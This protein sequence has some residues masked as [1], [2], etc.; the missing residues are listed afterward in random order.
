[1]NIKENAFKILNGMSIGIVCALVPGAIFGALAGAL[2]FGDIVFGLNICTSLMGLL[3]GLCIGLQFKLDPISSCSLAVATMIGGGAFKGVSEEGMILLKGTGD[4]INA[5]IGATLAIIIILYLKDRL[6]AYKLLL[7]PSITIISVTLVC[8]L[9]A[10]PVGQVSVAIG[11]MIETFTNLQPLLMSILIGMSFALI[12]ISPISTVAIAVLINLSGNGS[13]AANIG[14][15]GMSVTIAILA[16]KSNGFGTA[17]AHFLG[18]PKIQMANFFKNPTMMVPSMV[19]AAICAIS[20]PFL[21]LVGTPMSA[22]FG[23]S[24][25]I[26]PLGHLSETSFDTNNIIIVAI[27][28]FIIPT[29]VSFIVAYI[30]RNKLKLVTDDMYKLDV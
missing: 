8:G 17:I 10:G 19:S 29:I 4:V 1:M 22:G 24:G 15:I 18:S 7:L 2:G 5:A 20:V 12:I 25:L 11:T 21:N 30:F 16:Y 23:V 28:F 13:A 9:T 27:G 3:M 14:I 26:G 6:K